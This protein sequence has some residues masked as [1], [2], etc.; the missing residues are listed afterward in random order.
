MRAAGGRSGSARARR[1]ARPPPPPRPARRRRRLVRRARRRAIAPSGGRAPRRRAPPVAPQRTG[2]RRGPQRAPRGSRGTGSGSPAAWSAARVASAR[3]ISSA[4][5]G[6]P[7][8]ASASRASSGRG[9]D[10]PSRLFDQVV[11]RRERE[12]AG[13]DA[14][15]ALLGQCAREAERQLV[16][17]LRTTGDEQPE[18]RRQAAD[19]ERERLLAR[20]GRATARR[21]PPGPAGSCVGEGGEHADE[22]RRRRPRRGAFVRLGAQERSAEG[23]L[24]RQAGAAARVSSKAAPT[25]SASAAYES[26]ASLSA[27]RASSTRSALDS[28]AR[29]ASSHRVVFPIPASPSITS[30]GGSRRHAVE[31]ALDRGELSPRDRRSRSPRRLLAPPLR[32]Y[33]G[34]AERRSAARGGQSV[35]VDLRVPR[36]GGDRAHD[37]QAPPV[38]DE[39]EG[40]PVLARAEGA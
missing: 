24:L 37:S 28:A 19:R 4:K 33:G 32:S 18:P 29:T 10:D 6:F 40:R 31:E 8:E 39:M 26:L 27:G 34:F 21:R 2:R 35:V 15:Q 36:S 17:G 13:S 25:R 9:S 16:T 38:L 1:R 14:L 12:R 23:A 20:P 11:Q 30:A 7:P 3:A 22:R 5:N